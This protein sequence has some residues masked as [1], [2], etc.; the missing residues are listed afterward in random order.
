MIN[1]D[2]QMK[3]IPQCIGYIVCFK[4]YVNFRVPKNNPRNIYK[5]NVMLFSFSDV[6]LGQECH[7]II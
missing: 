2:E 3:C 1:A 5:M 4:D 6:G 7:Y